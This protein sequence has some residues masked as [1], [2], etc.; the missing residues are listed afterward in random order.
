MIGAA[1]S[2]MHVAENGQP[3]FALY[4]MPRGAMV[5]TVIA[6]VLTALEVFVLTQPLAAPYRGAPFPVHVAI[7]TG[8]Y[9]IVILFGLALGAWLFPAPGEPSIERRRCAVLP[10]ALIR[11]RVHDT[12]VNSLL[13]Q[14]VL[15]TFITGRYHKPRLEER[16]FLFLDME[17]STGLA[18]RLGP[19]AFHR[20]VNRFVNDL[21]EP[22]VVARGEIYSYVGDEV[23]ATWKLETGNRPSP[24]R[25]RLFRRL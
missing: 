23:I 5:G 15:T 25:R 22:I 10:R 8:I 21:T 12:T 24:L 19:L 1:Y 11:L 9:L 20:L 2:E 3:L 17:G 13:G 7:K 14:N 16:V 18:E 6:T 4:G